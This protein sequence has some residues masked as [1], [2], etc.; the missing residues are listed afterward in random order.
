MVYDLCLCQKKIQVYITCSCDIAICNQS[1][2][3]PTIYF[4]SWFYIL[5]GWIIAVEFNLRILNYA[6]VM[7]YWLMSR[8]MKENV[9]CICMISFHTIWRYFIWMN[10][11][12]NIIVED[13]K[14]I[15]IRSQNTC[16]SFGLTYPISLSE[17]LR[18]WVFL[19]FALVRWQIL[20]CIV[21][22][23]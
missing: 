1:C 18:S 23:S 9:S 5:P 11:M 13:W 8:K 7:N 2:P 3:W 6:V 19:P 22:W 20:G 21:R 15:S 10:C 4:S 12:T 17:I 16:L 14:S